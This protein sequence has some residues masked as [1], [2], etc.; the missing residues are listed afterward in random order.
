MPE[1]YLWNN[2][3]NIGI[4]YLVLGLSK[5]NKL[6]NLYLTL[7]LFLGNKIRDIGTKYL[8]LGLYKLIKLIYLR[9]DLELLIKIF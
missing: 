2:I 3:G 7:Y 1:N 8:G 9:L 4:K 6:T 5:L